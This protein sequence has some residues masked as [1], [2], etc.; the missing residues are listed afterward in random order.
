LKSVSADLAVHLAEEETT[1]ATCWRITRKDTLVYG[2]TDHDKDLTFGGIR[3]RASTG[4]MASTAE[5]QAGLNVD[6]MEVQGLLRSPAITEGALLAGRWDNAEVHVFQVNWA[7][8]TQGALK[9]RRGW[10]GNVAKRR[11]TF[12]AELRGMAQ[13]LQQTI[14]RT[15]QPGCD[16]DF[17]DA[18]CGIDLSLF[19]YDGYVSHVSTRMAFS[20][21]TFPVDNAQFQYGRVIWVTGANAGLNMEVKQTVYETGTFELFLPMPYEI[22]I[23]DRFAAIRG[24]NKS[25]DAC[26]SYN[27]IVNFRGF[28]DL[29]LTDQML[30]GPNQ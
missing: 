15:V 6:D 25:R 12:I 5:T 26:I 2:F 14:G 22:E 19:V 27:N 11:G 20:T 30:R 10:L 3:Y 13:K 29:P 28:P 9:L 8:L 24:C 17:G 23:G 7:D 4:F 16:A 1:L 18:Q 21:T